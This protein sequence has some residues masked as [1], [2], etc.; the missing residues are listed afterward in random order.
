MQSPM[1]T[2]TDTRGSAA[3][4]HVLCCMCRRER[5]MLGWRHL[6]KD[7]SALY[8]HGYCPPCSAQAFRELDAV[9]VHAS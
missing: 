9:S 5:T 8:S 2:T 7:A 6:P 1:R 4:I 3:E